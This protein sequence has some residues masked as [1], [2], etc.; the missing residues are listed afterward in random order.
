MMRRKGHSLH[1]FPTYLSH[2]YNPRNGMGK[3]DGWRNEERSDSE[4]CPSSLPCPSFL[5]PPSLVIS[6]FVGG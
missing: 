6:W 5:H 3:G 1:S 4:R 2:G